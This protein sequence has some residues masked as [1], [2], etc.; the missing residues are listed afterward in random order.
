MANQ[1][2]VLIIEDENNI[3]R[4]IS[5]IL[6]ANQ[7]EVIRAENGRDGLMMITSYCQDI[8]IL[9]LGLSLIHILPGVMS[10]IKDKLHLEELCVNGKTVGENIAEAEVYDDRVIRPAE[11]PLLPEGSLV[12]M[13]IRDS[14]YTDGV[15]EAEN[16][17]GELY[18]EER[19]RGCLDRLAPRP[20]ESFLGEVKADVD[21]F[22]GGADQFD[23]ITMLLLRY[24]GGEE[25][26]R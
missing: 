11:D 14:L 15:T 16:P 10:R 23:D 20:L 3:A 8:I 2:T 7:Y 19:L 17:A 22:A 21:A 1:H 4:F 24:Y 25:R 26:E 12:E 6:T 13:C 5:T 9:D 18:G